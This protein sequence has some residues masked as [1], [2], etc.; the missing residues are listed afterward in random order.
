MEPHQRN[1]SRKQH[2]LVPEEKQYSELIEQLQQHYRYSDSERQSIDRVHARLLNAPFVQQR[3]ERHLEGPLQDVEANALR[4]FIS[5]TREQSAGKKRRFNRSTLVLNM[6]AAVL[7]IG[8]LAGTFAFLISMRQ[9][10]T[11]QVGTQ[12]FRKT[13][14]TLDGV[15]HHLYMVNRQIGWQVFQYG[16]STSSLSSSIA[17]RTEDGGKTWKPMQFAEKQANE[18]SLYILDEMV[19][20]ITTKNITGDKVSWTTYR[21]INGGTNWEKLPSP[22]STAKVTFVDQNYGWIIAA[23]EYVSQGWNQDAEGTALGTLY[24]F[25]TSDGGK[26]WKKQETQGLPTIYGRT[27]PQ[28]QFLNKERG[29]LVFHTLE[30]KAKSQLLFTTTDGGKTWKSL[31]LELPSPDVLPE[32]KTSPSFFTEQDGYLLMSFNVENTST[33]VLFVYTTHDGGASWGSPALLGTYPRDAKGRPVFT[34]L[35][36]PTQAATRQDLD[37]GQEQLLLST[38]HYGAWDSH[39]LSLPADAEKSTLFDCQLFASGSGLL[40]LRDK[41][42]TII[43]YQTMDGGETWQQLSR[44]DPPR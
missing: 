38:Q 11:A 37:N 1:C 24:L 21:T 28:I 2:D 35:F 5:P 27:E 4:Q 8:I 23:P 40:L 12:S 33:F 15:R 3:S 6:I 10:Q 42:Q 17:Y 16:T 29:F 25:T 43:V 30:D 26:T 18:I 41:Q 44:L 14:M 32:L 9:P 36:S 20:W 22:F 39:P 34:D 19:A 31:P 7:L 13:G